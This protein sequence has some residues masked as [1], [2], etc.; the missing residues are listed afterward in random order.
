M[1]GGGSDLGQIRRIEAGGPDDM[2]GAGL[3]GQGSK[4]HS[5]SRGGEIDH[6]LRLRKGLQRIIGHGDPQ[7]R[8]AHRH[9]HILTHPVMTRALQGGHQTGR[10]RGVDMLDQHPAHAARCARDDDP[11]QLRHV[12]SPK[13]TGAS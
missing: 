11:R 12:L 1:A 3:R 4:A 2:G 9:T 6:R 10:P 8:T 13:V 5:G 7:R